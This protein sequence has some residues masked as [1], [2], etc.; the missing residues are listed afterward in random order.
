MLAPAGKTS[1]MAHSAVILL[2]DDDPL[3]I[4][5]R[6]AV[7]ERN[8]YRVLT[9][10]T[11]EDGLRVLR[12]QH[13]DLVLS[14]HFLRDKRGTA[15]AEEMKRLKPH[16]PVAILSAAAEVP[17]GIEKADTFITKLEEIPVML[18]EIAR[19]LKSHR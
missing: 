7:L 6:R 5:T 19:L 11:A 12:E 9:A 3:G 4:Q 1:V 17:E 13:V 8:G 10:S 18:E 16:V 14:D 15:L 2:V